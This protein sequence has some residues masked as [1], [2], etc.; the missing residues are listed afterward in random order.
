MYKIFCLFCFPL[1]NSYLYS[2]HHAGNLK[3]LG[4]AIVKYGLYS[5]NI[6]QVLISDFFNGSVSYARKKSE[7]VPVHQDTQFPMDW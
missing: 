1:T 3:D 2:I 5:N 6:L 7:S 4:A